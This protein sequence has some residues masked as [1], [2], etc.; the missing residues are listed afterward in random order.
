MKKLIF[1][2]I[3]AVVLVLLFW[4]CS[5]AKQEAKSEQLVIASWN[6]QNLFD[7]ADN[8]FEY[9]EFK[10]SAGWNNEKYQARLHGITAALKGETGIKA[11]I[12]AVMEV[13]NKAV[14]E[15]LAEKSFL[16]YR[17]IFFAGAPA[18]SAEAQT[19]QTDTDSPLDSA[20]G[21]GVLSALPFFQTS[22]HSFHSPDGSIP[23]PI[24]E[25]WVDTDSGPL[26]LFV[27]HW[28]SKLGGDSKTE[29]MR[30]AGAALIV[31][32]L[33]EIETEN[34][35]TPVIIM[36]DLNEN[37]DEFA[38]IGASYPCALLPDTEQAVLI[39]R[40]TLLGAR[41]NS[42]D[43]LVL[44]REMPPRTQFFP[45]K[46]KAF[47]SPWFELKEGLHENR[48]ASKS[49]AI[50]Q[51]IPQGS[52]FYKGD[53][54]TIDHFLL[55]DALFSGIGWNYGHF[56]VLTEPPFANGIGEPHSYNPRTGNGLSDH[57][58]IVLVL[59]KL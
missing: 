37:H 33:L 4:S 31:R 50:Y 48:N 26:A 29:A 39:S 56:R 59:Y 58:P 30:R 41:P 11:D 10:N 25:V 55:N 20:I 6:M 21:L 12:L 15:D 24:L 36:G 46:T 18:Y 28:K 19:D 7:G 32:R 51:A 52:Y 54:E 23:R 38:R 57:L 43:F 22:V 49:Q 2:R 34:P 3:N 17:W 45:E 42:Q 40:K 47:Y 44:S 8:G 14:I 16:N 5:L 13:E 1:N 53:W 9:D 35:G 27:C